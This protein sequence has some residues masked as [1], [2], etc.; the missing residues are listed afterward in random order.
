MVSTK[1]QCYQQ[2]IQALIKLGWLINWNK[3]KLK[4]RILKV[5][6]KVIQYEVQREQLWSKCIILF[7][8]LTL[9][10][11]SDMDYGFFS[12]VEITDKGIYGVFKPI[13]N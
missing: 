5:S 9:S 7:K 12:Y 2:T 1:N 13:K 6:T 10:K 11:S 8:I 4:K 3:S